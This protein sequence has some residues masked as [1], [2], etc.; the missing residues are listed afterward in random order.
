M[1]GFVSEHRDVHG[2]ES[3]CKVL[4][5]ARSTHYRHAARA[6]DPEQQPN[7][8]WKDRTLGGEIERAWSET[9][10]MYGARKAWRQLRREG[11][12]VARCE[13]PTAHRHTVQGA[14]GPAAAARMRL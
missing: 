5:V 10:R 6:A 4:Q 3:I 8:W 7:R 13:H 9:R 12:G 14:P 1:T 2:V 11:F